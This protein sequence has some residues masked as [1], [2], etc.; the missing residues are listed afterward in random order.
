VLSRRDPI[1]EEEDPMR[2]ARATQSLPCPRPPRT[3]H[4]APA[5]ALLLAA[6]LG[7]CKED[8]KKTELYFDDLKPPVGIGTVVIVSDKSLN[9]STGGEITILTTVPADLDKD[10]LDR[11]MDSFFRQAKDRRGFVGGKPARIDLK[12]YDAEAKAKAGG[13]D[14]LGRI[15]QSSPTEKEPART[16]NQKLPLLKW[17]KKALAPNDPLYTGELKPQLL[18][19]ASKM[20]LELTLPFVTDDGSGKY[21]EELTFQ[22]ACTDFVSSA[23]TLF[24][25]IPSLQRLTFVGKH[26][27][28]TVIKIALSREQYE[29]LNLRQVEE[30]LGAFHGKLM[31]DMLSTKGGMPEKVALA[32]V[33]KQRLKVYKEVLGKLPKEQVELA[34][35]LTK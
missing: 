19:D 12:F 20:S 2:T 15:L 35:S 9:P 13:A 23:I 17:A 7:G 25:K 16:N 18:A 29:K 1:D 26:Q 14:F 28:E 21:L 32:R 33:M 34:K 22:R 27:G 31:E 4:G 30:N 8:P 3:R 10:D 5:A 11:L 6:L 24:E